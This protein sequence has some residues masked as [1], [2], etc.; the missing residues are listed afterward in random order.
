MDVTIGFYTQKLIKMGSFIKIGAV[1]IFSRMAPLGGTVA[2]PGRRRWVER[3]VWC[4]MFRKEILVT[5][6]KAGAPPACR[7]RAIYDLLLGG[8]GTTPP[9]SLQRVKEF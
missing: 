3:A 7:F 4:Q 8:G 6:P 9:L 5:D 1:L 2:A